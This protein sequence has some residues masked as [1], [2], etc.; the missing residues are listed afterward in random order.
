M[1]RCTR[2][3]TLLLVAAWWP[4]IVVWAQAPAPVKFKPQVGI[5]GSM[6]KTGT[7]VAITPSTV[8]EYI[9]AIYTFGVYAAVILAVV[10]LMAGGYFWLTSAGSVERV[11]RA[12]TFIGGAISGFVL[13]LVSYTLLATINP[14]LVQFEPLDIKSIVPRTWTMAEVFCCACTRGAG[15]AIEENKCSNIQPEEV[16]GECICPNKPNPIKTPRERYCEDFGADC[17]FKALSVGEQQAKAVKECKDKEAVL[18]LICDLLSG[19]GDCD[20]SPICLASM[21]E[22][23]KAGWCSTVSGPGYKPCADGYVC[24]YAYECDFS[25]TSPATPRT[26][27]SVT[28]EGCCK[29][30]GKEG[31]IC[32]DDRLTYTVPK[33]GE[34]ADGYKCVSDQD[35]HWGPSKEIG[36]CTKNW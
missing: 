28:W 12:R 23:G 24:N 20:Q 10:V 18:G 19:P 35:T 7:E 9:K 29:L 17:V 31:D 2:I 5:P 3:F 11:T 8:G 16:G 15:S 32:T 6:F 13:L 26:V 25:K 27:S 21:E 4:I 22:Q 14:N 36:H 1:R 34:C 30:P 33:Q